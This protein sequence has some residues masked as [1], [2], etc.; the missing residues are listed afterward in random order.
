MQQMSL[1]VEQDTVFLSH[2]FV[3]T[4]L[5]VLMEVMRHL[6]SEINDTAHVC[7][8]YLYCIDRKDEASCE[9]IE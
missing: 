8:N 9:C 4:T 1:L 6:V 7:D 3:T 5:I 2:M